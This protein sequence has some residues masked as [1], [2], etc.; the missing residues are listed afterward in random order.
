MARNGILF[1]RHHLHT[2]SLSAPELQ[3]IQVVVAS[4]GEVIDLQPPLH[5]DA[6]Y[7]Y[8][9]AENLRWPS[10][11]E[12]LLQLAVVTAMPHL[13]V[14]ALLVP[15]QRRSTCEDRHSS[16]S[17]S[18]LPVIGGLLGVSGWSLHKGPA[19]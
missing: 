4:P 9:A 2:L 7:L 11:E 13:A 6:E 5:L 8:L 10:Q 14:R 3:S 15:V 1:L 17:I 12:Q 19:F 18:L 16:P